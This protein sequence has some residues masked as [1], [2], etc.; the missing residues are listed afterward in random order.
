MSKVFN[1]LPFDLM[2]IV[3][4]YIFDKKERFNDVL[5]DLDDTV[6][7]E[8][9]YYYMSDETKQTIYK[10]SVD[11]S[12]LPYVNVMRTEQKEQI[13]KHSFLDCDKWHLYLLELY[14]DRV[15]NGKLNKFELR[16]ILNKEFKIS[17]RL[18]NSKR[19]LNEKKIK[20]KCGVLI[21][22]ESYEGHLDTYGH[23][24]NLIFS[25]FDKKINI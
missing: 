18:L 5:R 20:C 21:N 3:N 4:N 25:K 19:K 7:Y 6:F 17:I 24:K 22:R 23:R 16:D 12:F 13:K 10:Y 9:F 8:I 2:N 11:K 15:K 14:L 1:D